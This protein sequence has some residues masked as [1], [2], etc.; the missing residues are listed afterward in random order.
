MYIKIIFANYKTILIKLFD[1]PSI[2]KW[3]DNFEPLVNNS[4]EFYKFTRPNHCEVKDQVWDNDQ[5][6]INTCWSR[7]HKALKRLVRMG[8]NVPFDLPSEYN[9]DQ[10]LLN[11]LHRF[12]T[13]N[14]MWVRDEYVDANP[15]DSTFMLPDH[16]RSNRKWLD[17]IGII[18]TNVHQL[19]WFSITE[20]KS[21]IF[22]QF[23]IIDLVAHPLSSNWMWF[24]EEDKKLNYKPINYEYGTPVLLDRSILGKCV[25]Q[26]FY[27]HDDPTAKDCTG[28]EG[29]HGGFIIALNNNRENVY[30]SNEFKNWL[31]QYN[32]DNCQLPLEFQI[33]YVLKSNFNYLNSIEDMNVLGVRFLREI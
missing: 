12:F 28:R 21:F 9:F 30:Q 33:G 3:F 29:S 14:T 8:Y 15:F 7:I 6:F 18:N 4:N 2:K 11:D 24:D 20:H 10:Y 23:P 25:L 13:Y 1:H 22:Q 27:E 19:E 26:S 31:K 17:L 32:L 16:L 5:K